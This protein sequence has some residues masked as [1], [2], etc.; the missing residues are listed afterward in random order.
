[1]EKAVFVAKDSKAKAKTTYINVSM[2]LTALHS[3]WQKPKNLK[4]F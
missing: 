4:A 1:M 3:K 2:A